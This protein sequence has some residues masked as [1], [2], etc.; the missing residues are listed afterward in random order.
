M[1]ICFSLNRPTHYLLFSIHEMSIFDFT[2]SLLKSLKECFTKKCTKGSG[3]NLVNVAKQVV[4]YTIYQP[5]YVV[6]FICSRY[7]VSHINVG[8]SNFY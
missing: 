6:L 3:C 5:M 4:V 1:K 8:H 2:T 7:M